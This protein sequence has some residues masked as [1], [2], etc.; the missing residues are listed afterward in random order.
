M[1]VATCL[2]EEEVSMARRAAE[3]TWC[4]ASDEK[5]PDALVEGEVL[6]LDL[7]RR[8]MLEQVGER[9]RIRRKGGYCGFDVLLFLL[10]FFASSS[11]VGIRKFWARAQP[12]QRR[13]AAVAGR[14]SLASPSAVSRALDKVEIDMLRPTSEWLLW[15]GAGIEALL[16]HPMVQ[17]YDARGAGWH[18]FDF[19]PTVTTL[20]HRALPEG[21]DL[22]AACRRSA[23][24]A[25]PGFSGRKRGDVQIRR[26]T[27]QHAGSGAWLQVMLG[28]GNSSAHAELKAALG[29]VVRTCE[30]LGHPLQQALARFDG[31]FGWVPFLD[32]CRTAGVQAVSRL[33][34][35]QL[36]EQPEVRRA[37]AEGTWHFVPDSRS[38]PQ[39]SALELGEVML[40]PD[41]DSRREDG[42]PYGPLRVRVVA[43]RY[44][45]SG[46]AE[47]GVVLDGWQYELF[48]ADV[49]AEAF[50]AAEVVEL[51]F[52]RAGQENRFAQEDREVGLDRIFSYHLPGQEFAVTIG[53]WV[54]NLRLVRGFEL[55]PPPGSVPRQEPYL[56]RVDDRVLPT[57]A[58]AP[59]GHGQHDAPSPDAPG[60]APVAP[61]SEPPVGRP[62]APAPADREEVVAELERIDWSGALYKRPGWSWDEKTGHL[63][64]P[65]GEHLV[66]TTVRR[67]EH[68]PGRTGIVFCRSA[69]G[70][71]P[72]D[73]RTGCLRSMHHRVSKHAE[74]SL[75]TEMA[76]RLRELL[77]A[78]RLA[79]QQ[80]QPR[81]APGPA[82]RGTTRRRPPLAVTPPSALA[83]TTSGQ[84]AVLS[85]L[86]LPATARCLLPEATMRLSISVTVDAPAPPPPWPRLVARSVADRQHRR[87]TW[88]ENF[89]RHALRPDVRVHVVISGGHGLWSLLGTGKERAVG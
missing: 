74:V 18:V 10:L 77:A 43:S 70:C 41:P 25:S 79:E 82:G 89:E 45:R 59:A 84:R 1:G 26:G 6:V 58:A 68:A 24:L 31:A 8:G 52:G 36:F 27:L 53:L 44:P 76:A 4:K 23:E 83:Q 35:P 19:D 86:F 39:R 46:E 72:C 11:T 49:P 71:E 14:E 17:T 60:P 28:P 64:C 33:T 5:I 30:R 16:R 85:S 37:L 63:R 38:G 22:P 9:V 69:G 67:A 32:D 7:E 62:Q 78:F 12:F 73:V 55:E 3:V 50:P 57:A 2:R 20:R 21:D 15:E 54:W 81:Q 13:L 40:T 34:R 29:V 80:S 47:H 42:T 87:K 51:Y 48:L 61:P 56:A 66:L 65:K 88:Q 75:P